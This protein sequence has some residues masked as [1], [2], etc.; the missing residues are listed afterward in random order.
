[1][2]APRQQLNLIDPQ[3]LP[4]AARPSVATLLTVLT[5]AAVAVLGHYAWEKARFSEALA[6]TGTE[7]AAADEAAPD[8]ALQALQRQIE[9]DELL[10]QG[11]ARASDLPTD[12]AVVLR[13]VAAAL[14]PSL[15]LTDVEMSGRNGLRIAG[16]TLDVSA[17]SDYAV[18]L[19]DIASLKGRA[20]HALSV[21]PRQP[22]SAPVESSGAAVESMPPHHVFVLANGEATVS[23]QATP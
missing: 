3:L 21:E 17:L 9:R 4:V 11:L 2:N 15:W 16:G 5:L 14:P 23:T 1:M 8:P 22:P 13:Q 18:K 19:G 7:P 20:L 12:T 10:S 6:Q